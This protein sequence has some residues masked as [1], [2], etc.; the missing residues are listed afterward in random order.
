MKT[1]MEYFLQSNQKGDKV[2]KIRK[3]ESKKDWKEFLNLPFR[4]YKGDENW[5]PP[6][7]SDVYFKL[8]AEKHPFWE[9]ATR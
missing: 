8:N 2:I 4:L 6:L 7:K 5:I 1:C 3:V 9:H